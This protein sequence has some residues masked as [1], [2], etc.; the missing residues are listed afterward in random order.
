MTHQ[1]R[2]VAEGEE[3][4]KERGLFLIEAER[5][6]EK[7]P[8]Y[9]DA[10]GT[11][12]MSSDDICILEDFHVLMAS[13]VSSFKIETLLKPASY[14]ATVI[15]TYRKAIDTYFADPDNYE[16]DEAWMEEIRQ[17]QDPERELSFGFFYKEQVY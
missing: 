14:N 1:G 5:P 16:F 12:I 2:P 17:A 3:L 10:S 15:R 6:D 7:F 9:E 11:H 8:I 4:G 13:G